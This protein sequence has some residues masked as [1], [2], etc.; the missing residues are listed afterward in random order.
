[1]LPALRIVGQSL[2]A[3]WKQVLGLLVPP[4]CIGCCKYLPPTEPVAFCTDCYAQLAW[5][6]TAQILKPKLPPAITSFTAPYLYSG[7]IRTA[8]LNLKFHD[9]THLGLPLAKL[10][11]PF[12]P[13]IP[14]L[15]IIPV[16]SHPSRLRKRM[17]NH[18]VLITE[19]LAHLTHHRHHP[20][21]LRRLRKAPPQVGK[22]RAQRLALAGSHFV[23]GDA[24]KNHPVLLVDDIYTTGAT[25]KACALALKRAGATEV[26]VLTLTYTRPE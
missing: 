24:V 21:T 23:A 22:T 4:T 15:L 17:Y 26:H 14:G 25:A 16:P 12:V 10:L 3:L 6:N 13:N 18:T 9:H 7:P 5:W 2:S 1:M 19:K 8:I 11:A 20:T